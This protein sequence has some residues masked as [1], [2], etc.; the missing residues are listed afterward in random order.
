MTELTDVLIA[1]LR[2]LPFIIIGWL[3]GFPCGYYL[4]KFIHIR[5][6]K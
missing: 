2:V 6:F 5:F 1:S 4:I 3:I